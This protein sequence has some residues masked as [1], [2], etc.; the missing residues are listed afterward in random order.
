MNMLKQL[1]LM[2]HEEKNNMIFCG[3]DDLRRLCLR[4]YG[5]IVNAAALFFLPL[6]LLFSENTC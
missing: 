6:A 4:C 5:L 3:F 2:F 1:N